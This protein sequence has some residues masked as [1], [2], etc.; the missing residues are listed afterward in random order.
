MEHVESTALQSFFETIESLPKSSPIPRMILSYLQ[1]NLVKREITLNLDERTVSFNRRNL[2]LSNRK[3]ICKIFEVFLKQDF[4]QINRSS[5]I[6]HVY[7]DDS[8][9]RSVR[10]QCC[11]NHNVVKLISRARRLA[12]GAFQGDDNRLHWFPYDPCSQ[13]WRLYAVKDELLL[14][15]QSSEK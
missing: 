12:S 1:K 8:Q 11:Y 9:Q 14:E 4:Y 6:K 7:S 15:I 13:T 3:K 5:L 2:D 10:Q